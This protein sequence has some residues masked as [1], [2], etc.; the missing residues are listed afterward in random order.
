MSASRDSGKAWSIT[1]RW[2]CSVSSRLPCTGAG[3][4]WD[5]CVPFPVIHTHCFASVAATLPQLPQRVRRPPVER[6]GDPG[7][8]RGARQEAAAG[9]RGG[10]RPGAW[11]RPRAARGS[12]GQPRRTQQWHQRLG[13]ASQRPARTLGGGVRPLPGHRFDGPRTES[14]VTGD[15]SDRSTRSTAYIYYIARH[16][17]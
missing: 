12:T 14:L 4:G 7:G 1:S 3:Q 8:L 16:G 15:A 17:Q 13:P 2:Q 6:R 9:G 5:G 10:G 11:L